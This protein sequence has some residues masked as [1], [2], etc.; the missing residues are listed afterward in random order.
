MKNLPGKTL[1]LIVGAIVAVV[2]VIGGIITWSIN[3]GVTNDGNKKEA[4]LNS[5]Y[6]NNQNY[7]SDCI[8]KIRET[9]NVTQAQADK[10][11]LVMVEAIKGRYD[12]RE[13]NPGQMFSA[14]VEQY[15]DLKG[16]DAAFERVHTVIIGCRSDYRGMQ[17]KLLDMLQQYDSW[18]TGSW[19][20]RFFGGDEFPSNNLVARVGTNSSRG[21]DALDKMYQIVVVKDANQAYDSGTLVPEAPFATT[22]APASTSTTPSTGGN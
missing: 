21:M 4:G 1:G 7:L 12:G 20:V 15:P 22:P 11:E 19:T 14:I 9:A 2:L 6:L 18:R 10:F 8:T 3:N 17:S 16:L 5:A 13:A